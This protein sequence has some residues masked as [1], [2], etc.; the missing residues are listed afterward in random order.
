[1]RRN[2]YAGR[3]VRVV[4]CLYYALPY[5]S[6]VSVLADRCARSLRRRGHDVLSISSRYDPALPAEE[7]GAAGR[8]VRVPVV[9][10]VDT[11]VIMP[12]FMP[13]TRNAVGGQPTIR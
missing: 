9:A 7:T 4:S 10:R 11:G 6:G 2:G 12:S 8:M 5:V 3:V 1:M 13:P